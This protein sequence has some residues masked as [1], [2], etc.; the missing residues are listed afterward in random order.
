MNSALK[1]VITALLSGIAAGLI[2]LVLMINLFNY[3]DRSL[4]PQ[5]PK[6]T[7]KL[8]NEIDT[9]TFNIIPHTADQ[10]D[11]PVDIDKIKIPL[12]SL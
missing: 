10:I 6:P 7:Q 11:K 9:N 1:D 12:T 4:T 8:I 2:L 5:E 3:S